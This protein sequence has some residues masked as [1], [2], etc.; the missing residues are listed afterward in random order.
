MVVPG[1]PTERRLANMGIAPNICP[2]LPHI[3]Y[4]HRVAHDFQV[5]LAFVN[6]SCASTHGKICVDAI[7]IS[8][9]GEWKLGGFELFSSTKEDGPPLYVRNRLCSFRIPRPTLSL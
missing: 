5:A 9:S 6:D 2:F 8:P 1:I 3:L 4:C 7:F